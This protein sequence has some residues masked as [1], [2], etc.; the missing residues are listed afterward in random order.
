M[1][2]FILEHFEL[3]VFG[4]FVL[5]VLMLM[6]NLL[7]SQ[8]LSSRFSNRKF[9]IKSTFDVNAKDGSKRFTIRI[10]NKN[11]NDVRITGFGYLYLGQN[12]DFFA[13]HLVDKGLPSDHRLVVSSRDSIE[14]AID[15]DLLKHV[16]FDASKGKKKVK[17]LKVYVVDALGVTA[18]SKVQNVRR[19]L[20]KMLKDDRLRM[21]EA[22]KTHQKKI[23]DEK[24]SMK[25]KKRNERKARRKE[26]IGK[27]R[28]KVR[29][30]L[31]K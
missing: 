16:V 3:I 19:M 30:M 5:I 9:N 2:A 25:H 27:M 22:M 31:K 6:T 1:R 10:Y 11:I 20:S 8:F 13:S 24:K 4:F 15:T 28:F 18:Y 29:H 26:K 23:K 21:K 17:A 14:S 7:L 12:I